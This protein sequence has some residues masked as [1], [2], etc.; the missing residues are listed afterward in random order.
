MGDDVYAFS[1]KLLPSISCRHSSQ[2]V[3]TRVCGPPDA[4]YLPSW[5]ILILLVF[6]SRKLV[7]NPPSA[8][9]LV[10]RRFCNVDRVL[11][12]R[13]LTKNAS[14]PFGEHVHLQHQTPRLLDAVPHRSKLF[15][16]VLPLIGHATASLLHRDFIA[17][18][19]ALYT[20]EYAPSG[21]IRDLFR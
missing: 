4:L 1:M 21:N 20:R 10:R 19:T 15:S 18:V 5:I 11:N 14:L 3:H 6:T 8:Q 12:A 13:M 16:T 7:R 17:L 2:S 9:S